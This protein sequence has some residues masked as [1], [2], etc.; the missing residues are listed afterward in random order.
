MFILHSSPFALHHE[1]PLSVV[2]RCGLGTLVIEAVGWYRQPC[3]CCWFCPH[4][5][6]QKKIREMLSSLAFFLYHK[7]F[8]PQAIPLPTTPYPWV[9]ALFL[10]CAFALTDSWNVLFHHLPLNTI[11]CSRSLLKFHLHQRASQI[12]PVKIILSHVFPRGRK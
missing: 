12:S 8:T 5:S 6:L 10:L 9:P 2:E 4:L 1:I 3:P 11:H 7:S